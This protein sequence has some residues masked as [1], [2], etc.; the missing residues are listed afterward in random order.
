[1]SSI[2]ESR[3][4]DLPSWVPDYSLG[5][6]NGVPQIQGIKP[7]PH[8]KPVEFPGNRLDPELHIKGARLG[9]VSQV[10]GRPGLD[11]YKTFAFD[12]SWISFALSVHKD[13]EYSEKISFVLCCVLSMG[14]SVRNI[15]NKQQHGA[16]AP[17]DL[18]EE[19]RLFLTLLILAE[20]DSR[21]REHVGLCKHSTDVETFIDDSG[22]DPMVEDPEMEAILADLDTIAEWEGTESLI[23][24]REEVL[25]KW[26]DEVFNRARFIEAV[27]DTTQ[28]EIDL[29][30]DQPGMPVGSGFVNHTSLAAAKTHAFLN[31]YMVWYGGRQLMTCNNNELLGLGSVAVMPGD[32]LFLRPGLGAPAIL[33]PLPRDAAETGPHRYTFCGA[34]YVFACMN[35]EHLVGDAAEEIILV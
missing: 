28:P 33:R 35:L 27:V 17:A 11:G 34:T 20:A 25:E 22:Y 8:Y 16:N 32:E 4:S 7:S 23:P 14:I 29:P 2:P 21:I 3:R 24:T 19:F 12:R 26:N 9:S 30:L 18:G 13:G 15:R 5:G 31:F 1:M 6:S 10:A